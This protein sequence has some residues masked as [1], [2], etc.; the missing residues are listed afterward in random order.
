V[1]YWSLSQ[2][3]PPAELLAKF[4]LTM[5][6][7]FPAIVALPVSVSELNGTRIEELEL[8]FHR[9]TFLP[10]QSRQLD[11]KKFPAPKFSFA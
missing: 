7:A 2:V 4:A 11:S 1:L 3:Q 10:T 9:L 6:T 8:I 5:A